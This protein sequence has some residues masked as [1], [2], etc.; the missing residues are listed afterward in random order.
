MLDTSCR[1]GDM[2]RGSEQVGGIA[3][4]HGNRQ[5][6]PAGLGEGLARHRYTPGAI[7]AATALKSA[8]D[9]DLGVDSALSA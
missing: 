3:R 5:R 6:V 4:L 7:W 9:L 1:Q 2:E 8:L